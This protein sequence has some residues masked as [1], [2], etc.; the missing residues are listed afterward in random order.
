MYHHTQFVL[1]LIQQYCEIMKLHIFKVVLLYHQKFSIIGQY[2]NKSIISGFS[3]QKFWAIDHL[4]AVI[5]Y[6]YVAVLTSGENRNGFFTT[7][8]KYSIHRKP[9]FITILA[10]A[11]NI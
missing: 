8:A 9:R 10:D 2:R 5:L 11:R 3:F 6:G 7:D 4:Q 1:Q